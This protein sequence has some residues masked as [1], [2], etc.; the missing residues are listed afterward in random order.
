MI[1]YA[2]KISNQKKLEYVTNQIK[3]NTGKK[4]QWKWRQLNEQGE[5]LEK[6]SKSKGEKSR[7]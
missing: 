3:T 1:F 2:D 6:L 5:D 7:D 4:L